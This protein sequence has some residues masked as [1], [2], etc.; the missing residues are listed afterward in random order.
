MDIK[1]RTH[2]PLGLIIHP[3]PY[4]GCLWGASRRFLFSKNMVTSYPEWNVMKVGV[5]GAS[6]ICYLLD[7]TD[8]RSVV[9]KSI[10]FSSRHHCWRSVYLIRAFSITAHAIESCTIRHTTP[11][12][13]Q[14]TTIPPYFQNVCDRFSLYRV[15]RLIDYRPEIY[16]HKIYGKKPVPAPYNFW[17]VWQDEYDICTTDSGTLSLVTE[18]NM[19]EEIFHTKRLYCILFVVDI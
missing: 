5:C 2:V 8:D 18:K 19:V 1:N 17:A 14:N 11:I 4:I 13:I 7:D 16:K 6:V 15:D 3:L 12:V 10:E 9:W